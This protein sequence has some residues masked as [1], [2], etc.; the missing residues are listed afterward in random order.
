M[1]KIWK[2]ISFTVHQSS[3]PVITTIQPFDQLN[4]ATGGNHCCLSA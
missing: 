4:F 3:E 2:T 1:A